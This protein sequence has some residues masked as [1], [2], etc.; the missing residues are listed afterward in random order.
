MLTSKL[1]FVF[2]YSCLIIFVSVG[3]SQARRSIV[4]VPALHRPVLARLTLS[5]PL[6]I[7][8]QLPFMTTNSLSQ[9]RGGAEGSN[10]ADPHAVRSTAWSLRGTLARNLLGLW[11]VVQVVSVMANAVKRLVPVAL[12]P[13]KQNDLDTVHWAMYGAWC[14]IMA[15]SEGYKAFQLKFAPMVVSRAFD[16]VNKPSFFNLVFSGPYAMGMFNAPKKRMI[17]SWL[18]MAG[19][20]SLVK[21]V[22]YLPYPY[23]S[24]VDGGV[25]VGLSYGTLSI[26]ALACKAL[27]GGN[28]VDPDSTI[29][30]KD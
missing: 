17:V 28:V 9:I 16:L 21:I 27:L 22:K 8:N 11:G 23:R 6:S 29:A 15:Y 12:Q 5:S 7:D 14:V 10:A 19:V 13:F 24:I 18:V 26:V 20:F 1:V 4:P 30:K 3:F 2:V 25:V